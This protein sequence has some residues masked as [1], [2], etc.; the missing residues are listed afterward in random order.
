[1]RTNWYHRKTVLTVITHTIVYGVDGI[2]FFKIT[3]TRDEVAK[4]LRCQQQNIQEPQQIL[5]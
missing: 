5:F 3:T 1:M 2:P 4:G